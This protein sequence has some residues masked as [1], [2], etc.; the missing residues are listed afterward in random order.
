MYRATAA[1]LSG[2]PL[3]VLLRRL[4]AIDETCRPGELYPERPLDGWYL[5]LTRSGNAVARCDGVE[6]RHRPGSL[7]LIAPGARVEETVA[8][9][10]HLLYLVLDGPWAELLRPALAG[11]RA[12][13]VEQAPRSWIAALEGII[14][15][16][17][18][19]RPGWAWRT[20]RELTVLHGGIAGLV[21]D[22]GDDDLIARLGRLVDADPARPWEVA[23]LARTLGLRLRTLQ[24]R[25]RLLAPQGAARWVLERRL[26]HARLLLDRGLAVG[27]VARRLGFANPYHFSRVCRRLHGAPPTALRRR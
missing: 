5:Q 24:A 27:E 12:L 25:L 19:Q 11:R 2:G 16:V 4:M 10:W 6:L 14:E 7:L 9:R 3:D 15:E 21:A 17:H 20:A 26:M 8:T 22:D 1:P 13:L 23:A 18:R